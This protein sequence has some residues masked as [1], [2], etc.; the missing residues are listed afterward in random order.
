[1]AEYVI[2]MNEEEIKQYLGRKIMIRDSKRIKHYGFIDSIN[3]GTV[4]FNQTDFRRLQPKMIIHV[5]DIKSI[6]IIESIRK[7]T[8]FL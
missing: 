6:K 3:E 8:L 2:L 4:I 5:S 7:K 1:M